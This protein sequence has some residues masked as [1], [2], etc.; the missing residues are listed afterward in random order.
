MPAR[1][2]RIRTAVVAEPPRLCA[3]ARQVGHELKGPHRLDLP[4]RLT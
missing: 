3:L 4:L 2:S 1:A